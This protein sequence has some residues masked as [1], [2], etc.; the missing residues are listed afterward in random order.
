MGLTAALVAVL[1][2]VSAV[3]GTLRILDVPSTPIL[4][5]KL[6][7]AYWMS[8]AVVLLLT[9]LVLMLARKPGGGSED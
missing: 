4:N 6:T 3:L 7:S 1:G 5:A 2:L 9:A 8:L